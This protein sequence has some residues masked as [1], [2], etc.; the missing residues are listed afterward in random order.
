MFVDVHIV[1]RS[2][3]RVL[4]SSLFWS[5]AL[6]KVHTSEILLWI[7]PSVLVLELEML[8]CGKN[9][10]LSYSAEVCAHY[11]TFGL[12]N[13]WG[14]KQSCPCYNARNVEQ[15]HWIKFSAGCMVW[16]GC[17]MQQ[18][19]LC[20]SRCVFSNLRKLS[21]DMKCDSIF[22]NVKCFCFVWGV[23]LNFA[24][25]YLKALRLVRLGAFEELCPFS[26]QKRLVVFS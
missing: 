16:S 14:Q 7:K 15:L 24:T 3:S 10:T 1:E 19:R 17:C 4:E 12:H 20:T 13:V 8:C 22:E 9:W 11:S 5:C 26:C 21:T 23:S 18:D 25:D 2:L 6:D